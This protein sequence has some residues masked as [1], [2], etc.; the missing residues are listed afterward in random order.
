MLILI[1]LFKLDFVLLK[2]WI[3]YLTRKKLQYKDTF[4]VHYNFEAEMLIKKL[5]GE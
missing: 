1:Q 2:K 4:D 3:Q 5:G